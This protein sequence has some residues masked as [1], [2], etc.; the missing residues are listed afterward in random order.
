[1]QQFVKKRPDLQ[2]EI[3][4]GVIRISSGMLDYVHQKSLT[5]VELQR[6]LAVAEDR[7]EIEEDDLTSFD[8][9]ISV[10]AGLVTR[11]EESS[12]I[13][14]VHQIT[15][16]YFDERRSRLF[17]DI[18]AEI[19]TTSVL[20][21]SSN[22]VPKF[23]KNKHWP[24]KREDY[25]IACVPYYDYA[26][27]HW[28]AHF[29]DRSIVPDGIVEFLHNHTMLKKAFEVMN[30]MGSMQFETAAQLSA[31]F[32]LCK[33]FTTGAVPLHGADSIDDQ[34]KTVLWV[35]ARQGH[36]DLVRLF[37]DNGTLE[38]VPLVRSTLRMAVEAGHVAVVETLVEFC[39]KKAII[40]ELEDKFST[41]IIERAIKREQRAI[42][43]IL[44]QYNSHSASTSATGGYPGSMMSLGRSETC[45]PALILS[46]YAIKCGWIAAIECLF[47]SWYREKYDDWAST[48]LSMLLEAHHSRGM[49]PL[50]HLD[51]PTR[52]KWLE[53]SSPNP[54]GIKLTES[55]INRFSEGWNPMVGTIFN[56]PMKT[57]N[58]LLQF[59][60]DKEIRDNYG[61]TPLSRA[62]ITGKI[63]ALKVLLQHG[64]DT[65]TKDANERTTLLLATMTENE[66]VIKMIIH[67]GAEIENRDS[68]GITP[69]LVA[70]P[71]GGDI[72][73]RDLNGRTALSWA[74]SSG[75][76]LA[77]QLLIK[78]GGQVECVDRLGWTPL[79]WATEDGNRTT[80][81][82]LIVYGANVEARDQ[83]GFTP[84]WGSTQGA[85]SLKRI[86]P[87]FGDGG[88]GDNVENRERE[89][90]ALLFQAALYGSAD[91]IRSLLKLTDLNPRAT[92]IHGQTPPWYAMHSGL[93]LGNR[94][95]I[96]DLFLADVRFQPSCL[97]C[98]NY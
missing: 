57:L 16:E 85:F 52:M 20:Y 26:L 80:T 64:A 30:Q 69:V 50:N 44:L 32:D 92:D 34:E 49:I 7:K 33:V 68:E 72:D 65:E 11:D 12:I 84:F 74:A 62:T 40:F 66:L 55:K 46:D 48:A 2:D 70:S 76:E 31:W 23:S 10:C 79:F 3:K 9:M 61:R 28:G 25:R 5:A 90:T 21:L 45:S 56:G 81:E 19:A 63:E 6:A 89:N 97:D 13:R 47:T 17:A 54:S 77:L 51:H 94:L 27:I 96:I 78:Q 82:A 88:N 83:H 42:V 4:S 73:A 71:H 86:R 38:T 98:Q 37:L 14:L 59:G 95:E 1:M 8:I 24:G 53:A 58:V 60:V 15:Q 35:A 29:Y 41:S 91:E 67:H 87:L 18:D 93:G 39:A 75:N 22:T 36:K 43:K